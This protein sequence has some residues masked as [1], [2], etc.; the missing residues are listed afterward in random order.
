MRIVIK[1]LVDI[2]KTGVRR[3]EQGDEVKLQQQ[4]NF[5]TLQQ[6]I[7][8][9]SL[10]E[11]N[12]DPKVETR[13]VTGEFGKRIQGEHKVWTYEFVIPHDGVFNDGK[14]P[15][16]FLKEDFNNIPIIGGLTETFNKP[17][18]FKVKVSDYQNIIFECFDK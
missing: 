5:Q 18:T 17:S 15:I 8:I 13:D 6:V 11:D 3:R 12:A 2:T 4:Q 14:D 10:I 1:T 9:R 16:G 7:N